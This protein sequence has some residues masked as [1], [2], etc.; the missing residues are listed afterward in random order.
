MAMQSATWRLGPQESKLMAWVQLKNMERIHRSE[1]AHALG[2]TG[3]QSSDLLS[4]MGKK[5]LLI[6]LQRELYLAPRKLPPGGKWMPGPAAIVHHL[7]DAKGGSWQFTGPSAFHYHGLTEQVP[8]IATVYNDKISGTKEF[9]GLEVD[10]IRIAA[11]RLGGVLA[12]G[13]LERRRMPTLARTLVDAVYDYSRFGTMPTVFGWIE[14]KVKTGLDAMELAKAAHQYGNIATRRRVGYWLCRIGADPKAI[15]LIQK[16]LPR[17]ESVIPLVP[18]ES[19]R[20]RSVREWGIID[21]LP[22]PSTSHH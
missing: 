4:R 2:L 13:Q 19:R 14:S 11:A 10:F 3:G 16:G 18:S 6:P 12:R 21:N 22:H 17:T 8:N 1:V 5:G 20:G 9:S 7:I 15:L